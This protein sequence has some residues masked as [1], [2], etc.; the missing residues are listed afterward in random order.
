M[1]NKKYNI[2][3]NFIKNSKGIGFSIIVSKIIKY[4]I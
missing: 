1:I 3:N 4:K 2:Y